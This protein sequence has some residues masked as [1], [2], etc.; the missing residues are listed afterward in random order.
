M[1]LL[2]GVYCISI[3]RKIRI[4][5]NKFLIF[6]LDMATAI[7]YYNVLVIGPYSVGKTSIESWLAKDGVRDGGGDIKI[8]DR[9]FYDI[10]VQL[11]DREKIIVRLWD[12]LEMENNTTSIPSSLMR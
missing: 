8:F 1:A 2:C 5:L 10:R 12:T 9:E 4:F 3:D 11:S 6:E 7:R